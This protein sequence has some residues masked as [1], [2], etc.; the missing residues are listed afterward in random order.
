MNYPRVCRFMASTSTF[1][2]SWAAWLGS[3]CLS[4]WS[5]PI[6]TRTRWELHTDT[7]QLSRAVSPTQEALKRLEESQDW[8][9]FASLHQG[10]ALL[11][12]DQRRWEDLK[13]RLKIAQPLH[14][15]PRP[16]AR[17]QK[18]THASAPDRAQNVDVTTGPGVCHAVLLLCS[19]CAINPSLSALCFF[20]ILNLCLEMMTSS[21]N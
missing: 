7:P 20:L 17:R 2:C 1:L 5:S 11:T 3:L 13:S 12:V 6:S 8:L 15:P 16:G 4:A 18:K 19:T 9:K 10:T 14:L 21:R